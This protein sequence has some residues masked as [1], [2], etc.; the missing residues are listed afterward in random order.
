MDSR[1]K[2]CKLFQW[3]LPSSILMGTLIVCLIL[4]ACATQPLSEKPMAVV[5]KQEISGELSDLNKF[6]P[7]R[8]KTAPHPG[9]PL[10]RFTEKN[11]V[12][13]GRCT[14][15]HE[16]LVDNTG[17]DMSISNHWR[18]TMMANAAKDPLW[19]A[20]VKS[21]VSRNPALKNVIEEKCVICH[22]PM[23]WTQKAV[24]K[25]QYQP[26]DTSSIFDDFLNNK[27][28]LHQAAKDGVSCTLCHQVQDINLGLAKSF[29]GK[30]IIDT[31]QTPPDRIIF[32]PYRETE[33][34]EMRTSVGYTPDFGPQTNDSALCA[35]CH[36]L[37][38]P[39]VD[40]E[41]N[42][43]GEFPEQTVYL[44]W[45]H[46]VY[47]EPVGQRHDI[48]DIKGEVRICQE[49]HMPHSESGGV[50]IASPAPPKAKIRDHF[51]Q[52]HFVGGN[53]FMLSILQD[54][55]VPLGITAST[56]KLEDTK[57]RTI[58]LLRSEGARLS[59]LEAKLRGRQVTAKIQVENMVGH[60]FPTGFPSRRTWLHLS[61]LDKN[62][63]VIFESGK[64]MAD[65]S[66]SGD[67]S[68]LSNGFEP[69]YNQ[70]TES[71]Q[72]QIYEA[73][74]GNTDGKV[75]FTLLRGAG[76]LKDNRLL[77][78][79]FDKNKAPKDIAVYGSA[80]NDSSFIGGADQ[81][82]YKI[83]TSDHSGPFTIKAELLYTPVSFAFMEDLRKDEKLPLVDRFTRYF[84]KAD[85][86]PVTVAAIEKKVD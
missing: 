26:A 42:V 9:F 21:E 18:S 48:G 47:G 57:A 83:N 28:K 29:S 15:C 2:K 51:S 60:K 8:I 23:A 52:H 70:I 13:S 78:R 4:S 54:N 38:T 76:Y 46:S 79:G 11:F 64:P 73:V 49:C 75:T 74:M 62:D 44:E 81:I 17:K 20:K 39:Y 56:A 43:A 71:D 22:M 10:V 69:H 65:G 36:T 55:I 25:D 37:Y 86:T 3:L 41:G 59:F 68:D 1:P 72:V 27:S 12:G 35:T 24:Q 84:D 58:S 45:L 5:A 16:L 80:K 31:Q 53:A 50:L 40:A 85:K 7:K 30:F 14:L 6:V 34:Q 19:Q 32:G 33:K 82:S 67:N 77:P 63:A 61:V 66:I